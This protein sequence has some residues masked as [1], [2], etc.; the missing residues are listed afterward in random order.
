MRLNKYIA[1]N[2]SFSRREADRLIFDGAVKIEN[3]VVT[4]PATDVDENTKLFLK[5]K[6]LK[7][8]LDST[9]IVYN[10]PRGELVT[11]S[12]PEGRKTIYHSLGGKYR[13]FRPVGRLDFTSEG[14][15]ILSDSIE[16]VDALMHSQLERVYK[17]KVSGFIT[18]KVVSAMENGLNIRGSKEGANEHTKITDLNLLPFNWYE[19]VKNHPNYSIV[20]ISLSEGKNREI[21][22]FFANL[23]LDV[24][25]LKRL[26][27]GWINLNNL[28]TGKKRFFSR[29]EYEELRAFMKEKRGQ[30]GDKKSSDKDSE[31]E[32]E[33]VD[34]FE[35]DSAL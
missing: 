15:L 20:K 3:K 31:E 5:G 7:K 26:S 17:V 12:D 4:N 28:P 9:V 30:N 10:K 22:R 34:H 11:K 14:V 35:E 19:I 25:D 13:G 6:L 2:S 33:F 24:L 29:K 18:P 16:I 8:K 23:D 32:F 27:F 21:R 1:Q